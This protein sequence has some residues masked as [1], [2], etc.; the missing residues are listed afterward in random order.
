MLNVYYAQLMFSQN[1]L[2]L[3]PLKDI[4]AK[5]VFNGFNQIKNESKHKSNRLWVDQGQ[6]VYNNLMQNW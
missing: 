4:K 2:R 1:M 5:P 6:E 3:K